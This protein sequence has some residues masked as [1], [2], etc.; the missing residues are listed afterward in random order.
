MFVVE[1]RPDQG[2]VPFDLRFLTH[3]G[4]L[5]VSGI[6]KL[7]TMP[8]F[9][10]AE[11]TKLARACDAANKRHDVFGTSTVDSGCHATIAVTP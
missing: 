11:Q 9:K 10:Y 2:S 5:I 4:P 8:G 6:K 3:S 7:Q 1:G